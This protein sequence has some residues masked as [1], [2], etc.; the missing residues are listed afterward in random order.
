MAEQRGHGKGCALC[1]SLS[2]CG[3]VCGF[4]PR[5]RVALDPSNASKETA[6][7]ATRKG[8]RRETAGRVRPGQ[9]VA[10]GVGVRRCKWG[11]WRGVLAESSRRYATFGAARRH[12]VMAMHACTTSLDNT[13]CCVGAAPTAAPRARGRSSCCCALQ[14][15][16]RAGKL[17]VGSWTASLT[18]RFQRRFVKAAWRCGP[19]G[20]GRE[21]IGGRAL[22]R[23]IRH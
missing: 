8:R 18:A 22:R 16:V 4:H 20:G 7:E 1:C 3:A 10:V 6:P 9:A 14:G 13:S 15:N 5:V 17:V 2:R 11:H 21:F 23:M 19:A 12:K